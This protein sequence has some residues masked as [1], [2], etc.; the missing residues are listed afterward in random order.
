LHPGAASAALAAKSPQPR[1]QQLQQQTNRAALARAGSVMHESHG[2]GPDLRG[3]ETFLSASIA[4]RNPNSLLF[5]RDNKSQDED[6]AD[7]PGV[8][9]MKPLTLTQAAPVAAVKAMGG[10]EVSPLPAASG[11]VARTPIPYDASS[12]SV[13]SA[14]V[15]LAMQLHGGSPDE[16]GGESPGA[17]QILLMQLRLLLLPSPFADTQA[18]ARMLATLRNDYV[19]SGLR[20]Q[21]TKCRVNCIIPVHAYIT[22]R[23]LLLPSGSSL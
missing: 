20:M 18:E 12:T 6:G 21:S 22:Y 10:Q 19:S 9:P 13:D 17:V 15:T 4:M 16:R 23:S 11:S 7:T 14:Q 5:H 3:A 1:T 2:P 8:S